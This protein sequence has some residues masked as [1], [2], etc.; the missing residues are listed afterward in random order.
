M[1]RVVQVEEGVLVQMVEEG[2]GVRLEVE[3]AEGVQG[4]PSLE[5]GEEEAEARLV[6]LRLGGCLGYYQSLS[7]R[8]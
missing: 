6:H 1:V 7:P 3:E 5:A 8:C 4:H 2:E